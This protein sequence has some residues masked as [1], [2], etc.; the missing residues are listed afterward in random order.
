MGFDLSFLKRVKIEKI[1]SFEYSYTKGYAQYCDEIFKLKFQ[2]GKYVATVK[3]YGIPEEKAV[4][5]EVDDSFE[6]KL[7]DILKEFKVATW[8]G[9]N[10]FDKHVL[11][12]NSFNLYIKM[13]N[14]NTIDSS[15]YMVWP[16]NYR[17]FKEA[18]INIFKELLGS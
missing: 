1:I 12:G 8:N 13:E 7:E 9:F 11:D 18:I 2:E 17:E 16:K 5:I 15:G 10:K 14:D 3:E 6:A 4:Q